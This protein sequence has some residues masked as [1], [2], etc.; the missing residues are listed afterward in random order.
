MQIYKFSAH[1]FNDLNDVTFSKE[2]YS[3]FK[4]GSKRAS[5][6][7]GQELGRMF[8]DSGLYKE[9]L[10]H[11]TNKDILVCSAPYKFIPV[12]STLLKDY[13]VSVFNKEWSID[14]N[15]IIDFKIFR[16]H[17]YH[18]DY[19]CLNQEQRKIA[20]NSDNFYIDKVFIENKIIIFIDDV[21]ITGS[22]EQR[23]IELLEKN[24]FKGQAFFLYFAQLSDCENIHPNI[25]NELNYASVKNLLDINQIVKNDEFIFN[26]RV[27]KYIL[28]ASDVE[29]KE[30]I[31]YQ[32]FIFRN[33]LLTYLQGN[34]YHKID[35]FKV[36]YQYL[37]KNIRE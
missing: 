27:V 35:D 34:N 13:F 21:R 8:L 6:V 11:V 33:T 31:N 22:H 10:L 23:M 24:N 18:D 17:S 3:K 5:R 20:I 36:N 19:G 32:S 28:K 12:A 15:P 16:A 25:E 1:K 30:F 14:H 37:I 9:K 2:D 26:T 29:F 7:F 4:H